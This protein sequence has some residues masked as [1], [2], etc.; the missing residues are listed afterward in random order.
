M[1]ISKLIINRKTKLLLHFGIIALVASFLIPVLS[2]LY[3]ERNRKVLVAE[4]NL[5]QK[6][7][8]KEWHLVQANL[9][10][11][12]NARLNRFNMSYQNN[13][14]IIDLNYELV[15]L[16]NGN[17]MLYR[18]DYHS[19]RNIYIIKPKKVNQWV[20]YDRL[21]HAEKF[22]QVLDSL[23]FIKNKPVGDYVRYGIYSTGDFIT[24]G[25][26]NHKKYFVRDGD[27]SIINN[28]EL[29]IEGFKIS[30][31]GNKRLDKGMESNGYIDYLFH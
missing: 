8:Q 1:F 5:S 27:I 12:G 31:Y 9:D 16:V 19:P 11:Q 24:Y 21:V 10:M 4:N 7:F 15:T 28:R 23:D 25:I 3:Y 29:P 14:D 2:D 20:Q 17:Y 13:G 26:E 18:I 6:S 30:T 22:F